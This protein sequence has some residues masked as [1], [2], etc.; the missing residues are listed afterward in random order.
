M[1]GQAV[2][3]VPQVGAL[4]NEHV[5][6][7]LSMFDAMMQQ[8]GGPQGWNQSFASGR[9]AGVASQPVGG[10]RNMRGPMGNPLA[11]AMGGEIQ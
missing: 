10:P 8:Q 5:Q 1:Y 6:K 7:T 4:F 9:L 3:A 11:Q 2:R